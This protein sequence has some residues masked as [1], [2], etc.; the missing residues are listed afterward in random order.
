MGLFECY[1]PK[2]QGLF[3]IAPENV[4]SSINDENVKKLE[5]SIPTIYTVNGM[6]DIQMLGWHAHNHLPKH[7]E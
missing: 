6:A 2:I 3:W 7:N 1:A 5:E 4:Q